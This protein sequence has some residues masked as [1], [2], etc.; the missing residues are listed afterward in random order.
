MNIVN[1]KFHPVADEWM[2]DY[3]M[4]LGSSVYNENEQ[5]DLGV[6]IPSESK[7][8]VSFAIV[9]GDEAGQYASGPIYTDSKFNTTVL[10]TLKHPKFT[11][12]WDTYKLAKAAG[13]FDGFNFIIENDDHLSRLFIRAEDQHLTLKE[14]HDFFVYKNGKKV[15][16]FIYNFIGF[17]GFQDEEEHHLECDFFEVVPKKDI[18]EQDSLHTG[19]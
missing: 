5:L 11:D 15:Q 12:H 13:V 17:L 6:H 3:C 2:W 9:Y 16:G 4:Y 7:G 1:K 14:T 8:C 10:N 19:E 18:N